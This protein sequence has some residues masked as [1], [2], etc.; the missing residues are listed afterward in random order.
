MPSDR[1]RHVEQQHVLA[2]A[3]QNLAL[4]RGAHGHG[5]VRVHVTARFLAEEFLHLLL[6][7]RHAG[8][9]ADQDHVV[10]V[11][12]LHARILDRDAARFDRALDQ[13]FDERFEL[14]TRKFQVQVLRTRRVGRDVRQVDVGL[15]GRRQF[16]LRLFRRFLQAL[17]REHVLRQIDA[18]FLLELGDDVVDDALVEVF[19]AEERVAVRRE[20]FELLFA[21]DV[22]DFDDRD[23]ERAAA[24]VIHRD[25]A[26]ALLGLVETERER[27]CRRL[28]DDA[29]DFQAGDAAR[30]LG[31]LTLAVVEV[32]GNRDHGFRDRLAEIVFSGLL[33]LAQHFRRDL[34]RRELLAVRFDPGVAVVGLDDLVGHQADVL[35]HFLFFKAAADQAF[36]RVQRVP[37]VRDRLTLG[38]RA[39]QDFV[40]VDIRDDRRRGARAFRVLDDANLIAFHDRHARVGRAEVDADDFAH[41]YTLLNFDR[42]GAGLS[43]RRFAP[44]IRRA[45]RPEFIPVRNICAFASFSRPRLLHS[46]ADFFNPRPGKTTASSPSADN[47]CISKTE[48]AAASTRDAGHVGQWRVTSARRR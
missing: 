2:V 35:L 29:L 6:H 47:A 24:Q 25:L 14:R 42:S 43:N 22:R 44:P 18:L 28:V 46:A 37:R 19:T 41:F 7:L 21:V 30:V 13:F 23:V 15:R 4:D 48:N 5:F 31:C 34:R 45:G 11:A 40:L 1:R 27:G 12:D 9:A 39:D 26:V 36:D 10:D 32:R 38:R 20:H 17:Q 8:H 33:H 16:D 3:R